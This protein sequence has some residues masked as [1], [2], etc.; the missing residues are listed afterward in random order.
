MTGYRLTWLAMGILLTAF[1]L[2]GCSESPPKSEP[3]PSPQPT[4][5][6]Q[7]TPAADKQPEPAGQPQATITAVP[8]ATITAPAQPTPIPLEQGG[9]RFQMGNVAAGHSMF[10]P[11]GDVAWLN[12]GSLLMSFPQDHAFIKFAAGDFALTMFGSEAVGGK[13]ETVVSPNLLWVHQGLIHA[14]STQKHQSLTYTPDI[15]VVNAYNA[16]GVSPV[17]GPENQ[18]LLRADDRPD[19]F[20]RVDQNNKPQQTYSVPAMPDE[21]MMGR[22]LVFFPMDDWRLYAAKQNAT[23]VFLFN[24]NST[25]AQIYTIDLSAFFGAPNYAFTGG[26]QLFDLHVEATTLWLLLDHGGKRNDD[27][28]Y[29]LALHTLTFETLGFWEIPLDADRMDASPEFFVFAQQD[30]ARAVTYRR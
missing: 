24:K 2:T 17:P 22:K 18:Y 16:A 6:A 20:F 21:D 4:P 15:Q 8:T 27:R 3:A 25:I 13:K 12:D 11:L 5:S 7:S 29:V 10:R 1:C 19:I 9:L 23:A 28:G 26:A 14:V 30:R